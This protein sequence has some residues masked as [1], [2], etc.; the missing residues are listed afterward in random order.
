MA[1]AAAMTQRQF[2]VS[3]LQMWNPLSG[4]CVPVRDPACEM[5]EVGVLYNRDNIWANIQLSGHP[6]DVSWNLADHGCWRPFFGAVLPPRELAS[7]QVAPTYQDLDNRCYEELEARVEETVRDALYEARS[8]VVTK[9]NNKL[10]R[11]LKAL[12]KEVPAHMN[13]INSASLAAS[14]AM[15][16]TT[17][18]LV[19]QA[20]AD[21][22]RER[23]QQRLQLIQSLQVRC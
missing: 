10:S 2:D 13:A 21:V 16:D 17:A 19:G 8:V 9:P 1:A 4:Q 20:A 3:Q 18:A 22:A 5:R 14:M 12:L 7:I 23:L 11:V 6:W 15:S